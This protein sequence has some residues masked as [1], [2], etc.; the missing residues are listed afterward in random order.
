MALQV[1][2]RCW[3]H[4]A[5]VSDGVKL[6]SESIIIIINY[7]VIFAAVGGREGMDCSRRVWMT[8]SI[9]RIPHQSWHLRII[10]VVGLFFSWKYIYI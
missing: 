10:F 6:D 2:P 9:N 1:L 4:L 5:G 8:C 7:P 3:V